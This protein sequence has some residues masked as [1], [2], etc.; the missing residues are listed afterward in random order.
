MYKV[1]VNP[2]SGSGN[3]LRQLPRIEAALR[4]RSIDYRVKKTEGHGDGTRL[5]AEAATEAPE[6][7]IVVGG[8]GTLFDIVNGLRTS[9]VPVIFAPCGTGNDFVKSL[10][11][12]KDPVEAIN[13]QL[14]APLTKIDL[15]RMNDRYF[16]NVG[17]T[18]FDVEVLKNAEKYK[19]KYTGLMV[20]FHGLLDAIKSYKPITAKV[21]IDGE[22]QER[23]FAILSIGNGKYFGGG[24]K[25]VP[26]A[27]IADG[28]FDVV[29]VKPVKKFM[30]L[31]LITLFITG[32][33]VKLHLG[34]VCRCR[35]I[36]I[37]CP[38]MTINMDG[39]LRQVDVANFEL[40]PAALTVRLP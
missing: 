40:L 31:P 30:I 15:C 23:S 6:G 19:A 24:M 22:T 21:T 1:I 37:D 28:L 20:Y 27:D 17:G 10:P 5:A 4:K 2:V 35:K 39:E 18:G 12:P 3:A 7:V 9:G 25:A 32:K 33:H 29:I 13:A 26:T 14:D 11:L 36:S 8:D 34:K 16:L 38:G